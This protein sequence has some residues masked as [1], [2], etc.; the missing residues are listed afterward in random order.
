MPIVSV[1]A[2][3]KTK[4]DYIVVGGGTCGLV[5][6]ARL[7][8]NPNCIVGVIEAGGFHENVPE[9]N[10][11]GM[12]GRG[13][14]NP[15]LDWTFFTE[16]QK[17]ANGRKVLQSRG[18]GLG[19]SSLLNF[20]ASVRPNYLEVDALEELGNK[21][22][23][24][25]SVFAYMNKSEQLQPSD[26][27]PE[28]AE[29]YANIP[30]PELHGKD[31]P[32]KKS[33][34]PHLTDLHPAFLDSFEQLGIPRNPESG[35][36]G[37][38]I[39]AF[40]LP[41]SVDRKTATRS[42]A[43]T[44]YYTPNA[45]RSNLVV[46]TGAHA[47][48]ILLKS[49]STGLQHATG[50]EFIKDG[51]TH[52]VEATKEIIL[53]AGSFQNP[54]LLELSGVGDK[55]ILNSFGIEPVIDLP[56]VGENLQDHSVVP[57]IVQVDQKIETAESLFD[58][59]ALARHQELY[60]QQKGLLAGPPA[61]F[62][63]FTPAN[64]IGTAEGI[65]QWVE[66]C[67]IEGAPPEIFANTKPEVK[68]GIAKQYEIMSRWIADPAHPM[69]L[70]ISLNFGFP[71][72]GVTTDPKKRYHTVLCCYTHPFARGTVHIGSTKPTDYPLIQQ[73]YLSNPVDLDILEKA[74]RFLVKVQQTSPLKDLIVE[75]VTPSETATTEEIR[76]YVKN[77]LSTEHHPIGTCSM[78]P[79]EYGGVVNSKLVVYGTDNLRVVDTS[80]IPLQLTS[81]TQSMA[82]AIGEMA[83]DIIKG[84]I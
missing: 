39:G 21:G 79:K 37:L 49:S 2:F 22:W 7:T 6:A 45:Q 50:V 62:M 83:A 34:P 64:V 43:A 84:V 12:M 26:V 16:P 10:V 60:K 69:A 81:N 13:L 8:E 30:A 68:R 20:M 61:S 74:I 28:L 55:D 78:L 9:V 52:S 59:E 46:L 53:S 67:S 27:P 44:G 14:G 15:D 63:A 31:G 18:K 25:K 5:V 73:N 58:P 75:Q 77:T 48:K 35:G 76:E 4:F 40:L 1:D 54:Q 72:P 33:F 47:S 23:N 38:P 17:Y 42:Y 3:V 66:Q 70:F 65:K 51:I 57:V 56:G 41:T 24:W 80:I 36:A 32:I 82:Y 11:P 19:G 29:K 71:V